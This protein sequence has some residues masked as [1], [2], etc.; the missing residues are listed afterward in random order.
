[1]ESYLRDTWFC[2]CGH[3]NVD[4]MPNDDGNKHCLLCIS[5]TKLEEVDE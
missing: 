5:C 4:H 1:M 3:L 2:K